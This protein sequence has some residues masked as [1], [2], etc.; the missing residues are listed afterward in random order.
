M[1]QAVNL[2]NFA[3]S[4]DSSGGLSPSALNTTVPLSKGGTNATTA[5]G[6]RTNLGLGSLAVQNSNDVA[7]TGG[8]VSGITDLAIADGG[9]GASTASA[10]RTN[11]G[12]SIGSDVLGYV[13]PGTSGNVLRSNGSSWASTPLSSIIGI[14]IGAGTVAPNAGFNV[15]TGATGRV[16]VQIHAHMVAAY[17]NFG[18][19][20]VG[21]QNSTFTVVTSAY[22]RVMEWDS[23]TSGDGRTLAYLDSSL[24]ANTTYQY[25]FWVAGTAPGIVDNAYYSWIGI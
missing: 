11:L 25:Y 23:R 19:R 12:L 7:I 1:T 15:V 8:S 18:Q 3:N 24:T 14:N 6:A 22:L 5:A 17:G 2:A 20:Q 10:A 9:T 16:L 13:A 4:L 21:I